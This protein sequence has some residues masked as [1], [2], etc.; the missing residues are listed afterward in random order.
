[1]DSG[2]SKSKVSRTCANLD[3][4]VAGSR[5][6][7][8]ADTTYPYVFPRRDI[9]AS[10]PGVESRAREQAGR[11]GD[12]CHEADHAENRPPDA[13]SPATLDLRRRRRQ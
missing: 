2:I 10:V 9:L 11:A 5:D 1:M 6:H 3:E 4:E 12:R 13:L 8:L 7:P